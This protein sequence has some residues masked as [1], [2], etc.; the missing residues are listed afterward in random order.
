M[1]ELHLGLWLQESNFY[2]Q[3]TFQVSIL[4]YAFHLITE[5]YSQILSFSQ[6]SKAFFTSVVRKIQQ[7]RIYLCIVNAL[8]RLQMAFLQIGFINT[9]INKLVGL[10][11]Y[12][13]TSWESHL[14]NKM[15]H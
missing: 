1:T 8:I 11:F 13:L 14:I 7:G 5:T 4:L 2:E 6:L 3:L 9:F 15:V 10:H 12:K